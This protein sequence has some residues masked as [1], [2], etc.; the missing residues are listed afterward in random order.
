[1]A[2]AFTLTRDTSKTDL[3]ITATIAIAITITRMNIDGTAG[4]GPI[5]DITMIEI[6]IGI[7]GRRFLTTNRTKGRYEIITFCACV[8]R[9]RIDFPIL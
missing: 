3:S 1:M 4:T 6:T 5:I 7:D 8:G 2:S 9:R